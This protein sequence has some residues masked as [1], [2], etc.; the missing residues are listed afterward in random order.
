MHSEVSLTK[1]NEIAIHWF[2]RDLRLHDNAALYH[3]LKC[4]Y[5]LK[6]IFIFDTEI[7]DHLSDKKDRRV[8]FIHNQILL[9]RAQ[10]RALNSDLEVFY[11]EPVEVWKQLFTENAV[12]EI[13]TNTDYEPYAAER[14]NLIAQ[15]AQQYQCGFQSFKDHVIFDYKELLK[16][17][18]TPYTVYTPYSK[19]WKEKLNDFYLKAYPCEKYY[20]NLLTFTAARPVPSL[21]QMGFETTPSDFPSA[22]VKSSLIRDYAQTRD[23][24]AVDG[25]SKLSLHF[26]FGTISLREKTRRALPL[27]EKWVNELI[28]RDFYIQILAH[29]PSNIKSAFKPQYDLI[30]WENDEQLFELWKAGKTG[31]PLV[32]AGMRELS[33]TGYM[34][35]R[36]RMVTASFLCKHLLIDWR[37]GENWFAER[38]LDFELASNNGGWQW[39]AGCGTDAAPYFRIFNPALQQLKFDPDFKYI[40][41]WVPE[42]GTSQYPKPIVDHEM[43]RKRCLER[44]KAA[45][46]A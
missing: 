9:L 28:W 19:K 22:V 31:Y 2:R 5:P 40:K 34:H 45:L 46:N 41:K 44:F 35:N 21:E 33:A 24:P 4:G 18:G 17:D 38:L 11:G 43:A 26:R 10:L 14:D 6:C 25:T 16:P 29:F 30:E 12:K 39:A 37:W 23:I 20:A 8:L 42:F 32:D 7:L 27:S 13:Y 1:N 3:G 36:V 15:L